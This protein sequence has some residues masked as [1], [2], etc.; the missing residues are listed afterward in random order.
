MSTV[1]FV[2]LIESYSLFSGASQLI[3]FRVLLVSFLFLLLACVPILFHDVHWFG[4]LIDIHFIKSAGEQAPCQDAHKKLAHLWF[5]IL[6]NQYLF[7]SF[8]VLGVRFC[9]FQAL[10]LELPVDSRFRWFLRVCQ[11]FV[12]W[13]VFTIQVCRVPRDNTWQ[14]RR[15][16]S[17]IVFWDWVVRACFYDEGN[18][19]YW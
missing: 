13:F 8:F 6:G 10:F 3:R 19:A 1:F 18:S 12:W 7:L 16:F 11:L 9:L 2:G 15:L 5:C 17:R 14:K 4:R